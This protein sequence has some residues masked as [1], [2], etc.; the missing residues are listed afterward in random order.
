M[1]NN[2]SFNN[3]DLSQPM[4]NALVKMHFEHPTEVQNQSIA[5]ALQGKDLF[6]QAPTGTGKTA[7]FGIPMLENISSIKTLQGL[8]LCPTRELAIQTTKVLRDLAQCNKGIKIAAIYGGEPITRQFSLLRSNPQIVVATPGRLLDHMKRK[9][10]RLDG[11]QTV[12]LDEAD[13]MLDMGFRDDLKNIL[14]KTPKNKQ[15]LLFSATMSKAIEAIAQAYQNAPEYITVSPKENSTNDR[16]QQFF[17]ETPEKAKFNVLTNVLEQKNYCLSLVFVNT[18]VK[19]MELTKQ[20]GKRGFKVAAMHGQMRQFERDKIMR[21]YRN[22]K[23]DIL[24]ATD[25]AARGVDIKGIDTVINYDLPIELENY[26]H[27]IGRTGRAERKG[28]AYT[29]AC[30]HERHKLKNIA[31]HAHVTM[32]RMPKQLTDTN[33]KNKKTA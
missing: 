29:F 30:P 2:L 15:T 25:V 5:L 1:P 22:K 32:E 28:T 6:V 24:V 18:K 26:I 20:L 33:L 4:R 31:R 14:S 27:R 13:R 7:A 21:M 11:I 12:V 19:A 17:T 16:I 8:V 10:I 3:F 23:F 9:S